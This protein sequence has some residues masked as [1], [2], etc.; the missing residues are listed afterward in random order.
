MRLAAEEVRIQRRRLTKGVS[1]HDVSCGSTERS[2]TACNHT[3]R[4]LNSPSHPHRKFYFLAFFFKSDTSMMASLRCVC[5][6]VWKAPSRV[7]ATTT[8]TERANTAKT[9]LCA[10]RSFIHLLRDNADTQKKRFWDIFV[11]PCMPAHLSSPFEKKKRTKRTN[12]CCSFSNFGMD[13]AFMSASR[14]NSSWCRMYGK[15]FKLI[16][17]V[18]RARIT[19]SRIEDVQ[20]SHFSSDI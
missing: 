4:Y 18:S 5:V 17:F 11:S 13:L 3:S 10:L 12:S 6:C 8:L 7:N 9:G 20:F 14:V 1:L 15:R 2:G 16:G 19:R